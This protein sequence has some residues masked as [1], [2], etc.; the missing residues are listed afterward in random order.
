MAR[1]EVVDRF[2]PAPS[3]L[4]GIENAVSD[5]ERMKREG[6]IVDIYRGKVR[7]TVDFGSHLLVVATDRISTYDEKHPNG[8]PNKGDVLTAMTLGWLGTLPSAN[9]NHLLSTD[10]GWLPGEFHVPALDHRSMIVRK[11][12]MLP[13]EFIVRGHLTG[14]GMRDYQKNGMVSGIRLPSDMVEAQKLDEPIFTPS[15][16]ASVGHDE[17]IDIRTLIRLTSEKFP[18]HD[19]Q[20]LIYEARDRTLSL[21][22]EAY[23]YAL[24]RGIIIADTKFEFG[25]DEFGNVI[26][27][28]EV[29]TPDS[30]RFWPA[31][32]YEPGRVQNS[33]DKQYVRDYWTSVDPGHT[34]PAPILPPNVVEVTAQKYLEA[35]RRLFG[36]VP[37]AA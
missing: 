26:L 30:S 6:I 33:F 4:M 31:E 22:K 35:L 14:S 10:R 21:Y 18:Q 37:L 15:T 24:A 32:E 28:D 17:N 8:I 1:P 2:S 11:L 7:D 5:L 36:Q 25:I 3:P 20:A 13:G 29:L 16:K 12:D 9:L 19:A 23:E 27:A 34:P